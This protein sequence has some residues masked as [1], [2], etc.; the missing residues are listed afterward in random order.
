MSG[1]RVRWL[2]DWR[3]PGRDRSRMVELD[4]LR[5]VAILLVLFTHSTVQPPDS[6]VLAPV[7]EYLR[8]LGPSGVDL[9]FVL[10]GF[11]VGGLLFKELRETGHLDV[12]RFLVRRGFKILPPYFTFVAFTFI[13]LLVRAHQ[14]F[15][16]SSRQIY[17]NLV[18]LQNYLGTPRPHTWSL[19][20]EEHFYLVLPFVLLLLVRRAGG[21]DRLM[22]TIGLVSAVVFVACAGMRFQAYS[23]PLPYNPHY[24]THLR[25]DSLFFGVL[26]ACAYRL[27]PHRLAFVSAHRR[28]IVCAALALL[29]AYP[30]LVRWNPSTPTTGV[31]GFIV[32]Y[33]AYGGLLLTMVC[34]APGSGPARASAAATWVDGRVGRTLAFIGYFSYPIYLW[35]IDATRLVAPL[36]KLG[37]GVSLELRWVVSFALYVFVATAAGVV[38]AAIVDKPSLRARDRLFPSRTSLPVVARDVA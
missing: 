37:T 38:A 4:V 23:H 14:T 12:R 30:A 18:H 9:F 29:L 17:P 8:Y 7:L 31:V 21:R 20:V 24:A 2:H 27:A 16:Q 19:A 5:G 28:T 25:I 6:G 10:S 1:G 15:L 11:L 34:T 13:W 3:A 32:L 26:L 22:T 36:F 35:H 33:C